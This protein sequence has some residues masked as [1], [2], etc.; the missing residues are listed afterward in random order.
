[1]FMRLVGILRG[2]A[3]L[4]LIA[5][6]CAGCAH[7]ATVAQPYD[8]FE[9]TN[10]DIYGF[11]EGLD[12]YVLAPVASGYSA[13]TPGFFRQGVDNFF[14]NASY[15]NVIVNDFLQ[16][17][18]VQGLADTGRFLVNTTVGILG[19]FDVAQ[20]VGLKSNDE[21]L[22]QTLAVWGANSGA[23]LELPGLGPNYVRDTP[24]LP[25]AA[26]TNVLTYTVQASVAW[27]L[28]ILYVIN[29]RAMLD[30]VVRL[31]E[32]AAL[33]P[34]VF[35]RTAYTQY[36]MQLIYDGA[37]PMEELY[38]EDLFKEFEGFEESPAADEPPAAQS[39]ATA[40]E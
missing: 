23:Y 30:D 21:D 37:P 35:T 19:L 29:K 18:V 1:M 28:T 16:G 6:L 40:P 25:M 2:S 20:Y 7:N 14:N 12:R 8:P 9:E 4:V 26:A 33:D 17:K 13:V 27:P 5:L 32:E 11:N 31:R 36:R 24:D 34:Y 10:R 15:P 38:D 3:L 22:G 39:E